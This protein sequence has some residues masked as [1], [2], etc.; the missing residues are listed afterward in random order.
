MTFLRNF[1]NDLT[2][3]RLPVTAASV[4]ATV[5]ALVSPFG[6]DVGPA[7][8]IL[9]GALVAVGIIAEYIKSRSGSS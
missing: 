9:T 2:R 6:L 3:L 4:V 7:G 8:P 5:V 1:L